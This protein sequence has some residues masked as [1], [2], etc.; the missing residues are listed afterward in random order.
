MVCRKDSQQLILCVSKK[1]PA[2]WLAIEGMRD[3]PTLLRPRAGLS[4]K[5]IG[6]SDELNELRAKIAALEKEVTL[7]KLKQPVPF[8]GVRKRS[9]TTIWGWPLY[10]IATGPDP[11][12]G[13]IRGHARGIIAIGDIPTGLLALGGGARGF[14][15]IGGGATGVIAIGGGAVGIVALG[16]AAFGLLAFGGAAIGMVAFGGGAC[17]YYACG[18]EAIGQY[19]LSSTKQSPEAVQFFQSWFPGIEEMIQQRRR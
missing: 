9:Q 6:M 5:V 16:G 10:E 13:E 8:R 14:L 18:G 15:A 2:K 17:G 4:Q 19:V 7:L 12:R 1:E 11:E 3:S